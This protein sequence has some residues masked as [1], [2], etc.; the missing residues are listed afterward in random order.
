MGTRG[1]VVVHE[2]DRPAVYLY[3]HYGANHLPETVAAA[4][5]RGKGRWN[6]A[7]YL[8]RIIFSEMIR[9]D[10]DGDT[11]YG[12]AA[13]RNEVDGRDRIVDVDTM[14]R[15][16]TLDGPDWGRDE[17][18]SLTFEQIAAGERL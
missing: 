5:A 7:P 6:D 15:R 1:N 18:R 8:A 11:G 12:I 16:V 9:D 3:Q 10:I 17:G 13:A 4:L 14:S 2:G